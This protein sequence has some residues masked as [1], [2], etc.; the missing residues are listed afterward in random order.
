MSVV[1]SQ[2]FPLYLCT[3][4]AHTAVQ[5]FDAGSSITGTFGVQLLRSFDVNTFT[6]RP[7]LHGL[8]S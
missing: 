2:Y 4:G 3:S 1:N 7:P 5:A 8:A 6:P